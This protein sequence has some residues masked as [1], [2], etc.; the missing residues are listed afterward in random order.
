MLP[1]LEN[2][3]SHCFDAA[4]EHA[5][6]VCNISDFKAEGLH[7]II[8][9]HAL[10]LLGFVDYCCLASWLIVAWLEVQQNTRQYNAGHEP[11]HRGKGGAPLV[12]ALPMHQALLCLWTDH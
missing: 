1:L 9:A 7:V 10:A 3:D 6:L 12:I 11:T 2:S 8:A 4:A 5:C